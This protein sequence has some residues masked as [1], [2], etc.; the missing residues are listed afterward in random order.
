MTAQWTNRYIGRP[1]CKLAV[2]GIIVL[3]KSYQLVIAPMLLGGGCRHHPSCSAYSLE[4]F[5]RHGL[6][7]GLR[8]TSTRIW[9]C[10]PGG[11]YGYDPV[12]ERPAGDRFLPA[13]RWRIR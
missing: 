6:G 8:L 3:I 10:R 5:R 7:K 9:R 12:P 1:L 2:A 11:S 4:A 13:Q